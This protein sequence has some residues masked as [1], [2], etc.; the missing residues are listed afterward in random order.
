LYGKFNDDGSSS[1]EVI[2]EPPQRYEKDQIVILPDPDEDRVEK[3][4]S[5]LGFTRVRVI[6]FNNLLPPPTHLSLSLLWAL[7]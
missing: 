2:Y 3:I 4:A 5:L 7:R 1:A 6:L